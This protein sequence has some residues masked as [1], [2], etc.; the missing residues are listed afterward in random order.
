MRWLWQACA[1]GKELNTGRINTTSLFLMKTQ[2]NARPLALV[3]LQLFQE[4]RII[5]DNI[6]DRHTDFQRKLIRLL[7]EEIHRYLMCGHFLLVHHLFRL[8]TPMATPIP[9][10]KIGV[11][12]YSMG[13]ST[14]TEV[15]VT[16]NWLRQTRVGIVVL[17]YLISC[18]KACPLMK[19]MRKLKFCVLGLTFGFLNWKASEGIQGITGLN[20]GG[21]FIP[22]TAW[23][24]DETQTV[25]GYTPFDKFDQVC[26]L[27]ECKY[28]LVPHL[29][30]NGWIHQ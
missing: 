3:K 9:T 2:R 23:V 11:S 4:V 28:L 15:R 25:V 1:P 20:S 14:M 16:R 17:L 22:I 8:S 5:H 7:Q 27:G 29:S 10:H 19:P 30:I 6:G 26:G 24:L 12:S 18:S 13:I 21:N